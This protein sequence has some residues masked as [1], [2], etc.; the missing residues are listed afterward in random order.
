[1]CGSCEDEVCVLMYRKG[2]CGGVRVGGVE[3]VVGGGGTV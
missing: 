3:V 1:M 2:M